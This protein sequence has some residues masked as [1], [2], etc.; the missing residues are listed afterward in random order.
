MLT[1]LLSAAVAA[2]IGT[3]GGF[4]GGRLSVNALRRDHVAA[5][6]GVDRVAD[7]LRRLIYERPTRSEVATRPDVEAFL[8]QR[9]QVLAQVFVTREQLTPVLAEVVTRPE[10][11]MALSA[12]VTAI[13]KN[14]GL[15]LPAPQA[16]QESAALAGASGDQLANVIAAMGQQ[17][18]QINRQLGIG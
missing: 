13:S 14:A 8:H 9:E 18:N 12:V 17:M 7:D 15:P 1:Y 2:A 11:D 10:L 3:A 5:L 16:L 6:Q 4:V